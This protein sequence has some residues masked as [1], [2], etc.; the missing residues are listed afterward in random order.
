MD[1]SIQ[2]NLPKKK[3]RKEKFPFIQKGKRNRTRKSEDCD[4]H[5]RESQEEGAHF[6]GDN[7]S[8]ACSL[9]VVGPCPF[10]SPLPPISIVAVIVTPCHSNVSQ[11]ANVNKIGGINRVHT[12][13]IAIVRRVPGQEGFN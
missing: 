10:F 9:F 1:P 3:K 11:P 5:A 2:K 6:A 12:D 13:V 4:T 7:R 8:G